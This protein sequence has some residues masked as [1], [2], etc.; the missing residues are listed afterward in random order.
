V[1][2]RSAQFVSRK[3]S[4]LPKRKKLRGE[5]KGS[6][7]WSTGAGRPAAPMAAL[8][9]TETKGVLKRTSR[10]FRGEGRGKWI[11]EAEKILIWSERRSR[12]RGS[13]PFALA[14]K[15]SAVGSKLTAL[16]SRSIFSISIFI[17][18]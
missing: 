16:C 11:T 17:F 1:N 8:E 3:L 2:Y 15:I 12:P 6:R 10:L 18:F 7:G 5:G 4:R 14:R 13:L 9:A